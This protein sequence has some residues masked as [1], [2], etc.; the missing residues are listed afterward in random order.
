LASIRKEIEV[1]E[2]ATSYTDNAERRLVEH[3]CGNPGIR[4]RELSRLTGLSNGV[5]TYHLS[6]LEKMNQI[7]IDRQ[8]SKRVTRYYTPNVSKDESHIIGCIRNK[9]SRQITMYILENDLCT[10]NEILDHIHKSPS[11]LSWY[12]KKLKEAGIV[13]V[14]RGEVRQLYTVAEHETV[15]H[16]LF[17]YKEN[18]TDKIVDNYTSMV[19]EL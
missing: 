6:L 18:F 7:R 8:Q 19:E 2:I 12:L 14:I 17:K 11:T 1:L 5:L 3:I 13:S 16:I 10:F 9:I 4:Y 15:A